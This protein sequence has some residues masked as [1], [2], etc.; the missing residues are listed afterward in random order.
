MHRLTQ[1]FIPPQSN[2]RLIALLDEN[3]RQ[4]LLKACLWVTLPA[5]QKLMEPGQRIQYAYFPTG[6]VIALMLYPP[7]NKPL[8][9]C[10]IG[11]EGLLDV[12][13]LLGIRRSLCVARM[14]TAGTAWRIQASALYALKC[15]YP[16]LAV[17]LNHYI[18]V[19]HAQLT[20]AVL[21]HS[22]HTLQQ[23][24]ARLLLMLADRLHTPH[25][26]ITQATLANLLGVRRVGITKAAGE[27]QLTQAVHYSRGNMH[28]I[29]LQALSAYACPCYSADRQTY[30]DILVAKCA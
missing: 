16:T 6:G 21:C 18:A 8:A 26:F 9:L 4:R 23:R 25:F 17:H 22:F 24:L 15:A 5:Q 11:D 14:Q 29:D 20:Q 2:N 7:Q 19:R 30:S 1:P 3:N 10:L 28:L 12:P 27:L 13:V